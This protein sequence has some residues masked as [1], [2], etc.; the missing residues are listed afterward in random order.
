[1]FRQKR[2]GSLLLLV[3]GDAGA[4]WRCRL[5]K[6]A[7]TTALVRVRAARRDSLCVFMDSSFTQRA[8]PCREIVFAEDYHDGPAASSYSSKLVL[9]I[10]QSKSGFPPEGTANGSR[11]ASGRAG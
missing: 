6:A 11:A 3:S 10:S 5:A 2:N 8:S 7:P 9:S 4:A 1:M